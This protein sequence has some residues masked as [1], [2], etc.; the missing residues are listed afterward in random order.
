ML[1][2]AL[3]ITALISASSFETVDAQTY[4]GPVLYNG[5]NVY[6]VFASWTN[7]SAYIN[8][9]SKPNDL[10]GAPSGD[11]LQT[12][13]G[14]NATIATQYATAWNTA[15][16]WAGGDQHPNVSNQFGPYFFTNLSGNTSIANAQ[17]IDKNTANPSHKQT[18]V[19]SE[20]FYAVT[21]SPLSN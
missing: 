7:L 20:A 1:K 9:P 12:P 21:V 3:L 18:N 2:L 17:S 14:S 19:N 4:N 5:Y 11:L 8:N 10:A 13:W 16:S 6:Y 15:G